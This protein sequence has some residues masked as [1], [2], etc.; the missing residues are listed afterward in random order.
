[1]NPAQ[2][3]SL[4]QEASLAGELIVP[5][6]QGEDHNLGESGGVCRAMSYEWAKARLRNQAWR[7][8]SPASQRLP[9]IPDS[10]LTR[11]FGQVNT[12]VAITDEYHR[13]QNLSAEA[14]AQEMGVKH[15]VEAGGDTLESPTVLFET[16]AGVCRGSF[17]ICVIGLTS[18]MP[19]PV[20]P[21]LAIPAR[22]TAWQ[23]AIPT[24]LLQGAARQPL[25][26]QN[27]TPGPPARPLPALPTQELRGHALGLRITLAANEFFDANS[28]WYNFASYQRLCQFFVRYLGTTGYRT[29]YPGAWEIYTIV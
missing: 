25:I 23:A 1:M 22:T 13:L 26:G 14:M 6:R 21:P 2:V 28:G 8:F 11:K 9:L 5:I 7:G 3:Y 4:S 12:R 24:V 20:Q 29:E 19:K 18:A 10:P 17:G 27:R 15:I 16:A